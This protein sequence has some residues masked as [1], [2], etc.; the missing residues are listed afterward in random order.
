[1]PIVNNFISQAWQRYRL[2]TGPAREIATLL[3]AL[4][5]GLFVVPLAIWLGGHLIL[6][7]YQRD[8][9]VGGAGN[10]GGPV[11]LWIDYLRGLLQGSIAYWIVLVG[12]YV[13]YLVLR[14]GRRLL[15]T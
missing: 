2:Q 14:L 4:C 6:G 3:L 9:G 11:A 12:P 13:I 15:R 1:M 7:D 8:P 10:I 5:F